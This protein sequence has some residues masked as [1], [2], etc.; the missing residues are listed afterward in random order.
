MGLSPSEMLS[1]P[2]SP[3]VSLELVHVPAGEFTMGQED[4]YPDE[5]PVG[6]V[7][8]DRP[9]WIGR[10]EVTNEQFALF[11]PAHDS[12]WENND[13]LKFGPGEMGWS[14][15]RPAQPVVRVS[16]QQAMAFCRWLSQKTG[17]QCTL[18][19]EAQWEYACRAGTTTP[20]WYGTPHGDFSPFANVSDLS[21]QT[22]DPFGDPNRGEV[23]APWRPADPRFDDHSR[24]SA[25]VG[26]Y[27]PNPWGL[28]DVH[29]NVAEWTRSQYRPYP[30]RDDDGRNS[31]SGGRRTV[32]GGSWYDRPERCRAAFRQPYLADQPVY[33]VGFRVI[34]EPARDAREVRP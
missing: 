16:W 12:R 31:P 25:P 20:L 6:R 32:R 22:I 14:L 8:I 9:F 30:Y 7:K 17:R 34:C 13:F 29:G 24:V 1:I 27:R 2:L 33:D 18:P 26:S 3:A 11:D 10:F 5:R 21:H 4:G 19:T 28:F 23:I 15:A